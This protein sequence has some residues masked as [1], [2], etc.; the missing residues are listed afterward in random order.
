MSITAV[1]TT[2]LLLTANIGNQDNGDTYET[3]SETVS[4]GD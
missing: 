4:L 1:G 3:M 2:A